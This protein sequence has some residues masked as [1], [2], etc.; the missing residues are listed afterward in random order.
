M[1]TNQ[2]L[3]REQ[4]TN[5]LEYMAHLA[6]AAIAKDTHANNFLEVTFRDAE[7]QEWTMFF[8][9]KDADTPTNKYNQVLDDLTGLAHEHY[10]V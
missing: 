8:Q 10:G 3:T 2:E 7:E 5:A 9:K 1:E 4:V 6:M